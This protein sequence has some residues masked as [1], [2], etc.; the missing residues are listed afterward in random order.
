MHSLAVLGAWHAAPDAP[1]LTAALL[2]AARS[3][4][5][6][7]HVVN[8]FQLLRIVWSVAALEVRA[9]LASSSILTP[10]QPP[11]LTPSRPLT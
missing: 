3:Q 8:H 7:H 6:G 10:A 1:P 5:L 11:V 9:R 2:R 4:L